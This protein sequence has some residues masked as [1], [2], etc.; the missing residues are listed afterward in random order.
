MVNTQTRKI[1]CIPLSFI[2]N[3]PTAGIDWKHLIWTLVDWFVDFRISPQRRLYELVRL[4]PSESIHRG[5][6]PL[7]ERA[8]PSP[9]HAC[10]CT[11]IVPPHR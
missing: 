10:A 2:S 9:A 4:F 6:C 11:I 8:E 7:A 1:N 5:L 3:N